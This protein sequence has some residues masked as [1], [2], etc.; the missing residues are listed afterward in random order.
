MEASDAVLASG[1][2]L[3]HTSNR[4]A[5]VGWL[6]ALPTQ[7]L[8]VFDPGPLVADIPP[9]ALRS[10]L[11]RTDWLTCN[12]REAAMLGA[13]T[14]GRIGTIVRTGAAGCTVQIVD[15]DPVEVPGFPVTGPIDTNGAGDTH[16][17][18]FIAALARD[19]APIEAARWANAAAA[20][21]VT[22]AGPATAPTSAEI[23]ALLSSLRPG[24][25]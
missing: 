20:I 10:V 23:S 6:G 13:R 8:V 4:A 12:A 25:I 19:A 24:T 1:Y 15:A 9:D 7:A 5:I 17:G 18:A 22:R 14:M 11:E 21:S 3:L 16:T 2:S